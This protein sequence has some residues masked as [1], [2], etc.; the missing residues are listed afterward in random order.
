MK[1]I[2]KDCIFVT[3]GAG[4]IGSAVIRRIL[5]STESCVVN[6]DSLTYAGNLDTLLAESDHE[7]YEFSQTDIR[8]IDGLRKLFSRFQPSAVMHLAA[9]S[10]VDRSIDQPSLFLE[11]NIMGTYTL[12]EAV[13]EYINT[14]NSERL[15]KF[16]FHHVS[17]DEVYGS[18]GDEGLFTENSPYRPRS[19]YAA[20]KAAADHLVRAWAETY[21]IPA[22][23]SNCSNNY[24]PYQ[25]PEKLIP[26]VIRKALNNQDIPVYGSGR[27][28]RDWLYVDDHASALILILNRGLSGRTYNVGGGGD[29]EKSNLSLVSA[30]CSDLDRIRPRR[31]G[32]SYSDLI[33]F[34]ADR[35][36]HDYRYAIDSSRIQKELGW[37]PEQTFTSGLEKTVRWYLTNQK[38]VDGVMRSQYDGERLGLGVSG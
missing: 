3:G 4:F 21:G 7:R 12:L 34:V 13:R 33:S 26:V 20:S 25:Y 37:Q 19:P 11:T 32:N 22:V 5:H 31:N 10:H 35:P 23:V 29:S 28:I 15:E 38:W 17:T 30:I 18:L 6:I 24:G 27:N 36:G 1:N 16:R 8:D 2:S 14:V 9:E